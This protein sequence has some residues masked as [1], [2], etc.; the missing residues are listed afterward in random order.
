MVMLTKGYLVDSTALIA[1]LG[2]KNPQAPINF[3]TKLAKARRLRVPA[4][5][6]REVDRQDDKLRT[7]ARRNWD[8]LVVIESKEVLAYHARVIRTYSRLFTTA[9][10]AADPLLVC[11]AMYLRDQ[12]SDQQW[13]VVTDDDGVAVAL[14]QERIFSLRTRSFRMDAGF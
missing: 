9:S 10:G 8:H 14:N 2:G 3:L 7:W 6:L 1:L 4:A 5:V 13:D 11:T 12:V